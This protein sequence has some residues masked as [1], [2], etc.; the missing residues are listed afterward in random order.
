MKTLALTVSAVALAAATATAAAQWLAPG[1][2][3]Y[4]VYGPYAPP[5]AGYGP[6]AGPWGGAPMT[7]GQFEAMAEQQ[8]DFAEQQGK[9][10]QNMMDN[11]R[12]WHEAFLPPTPFGPVSSLPRP[13]MPEP[14]SFGER[15]KLG[16]LPDMPELP[17][18]PDLPKPP[19]FGERPELPNGVSMPEMPEM[20]EL[21]A[22]YGADREARQADLDAWR[23][24]MQQRAAARREAMRQLSERRRAA[25]HGWGWPAGYGVPPT[26]APGQDQAP[27]EQ[28]AGA[29]STGTTPAAPGNS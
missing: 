29:A 15:P 23:E 8:R 6:W 13:K 19:A 17:A 24:T 14:P 25:H 10:I 4:A 12:A 7:P 18:M 21:P 28:P 22:G 11:Q 5:I 26:P 1:Y 16:E 2:G 20:P 9:A 27:A 3:P